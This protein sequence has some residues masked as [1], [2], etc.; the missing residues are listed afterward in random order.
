MRLSEP[1]CRARVAQARVGRL[2]TTG[3][4]G[5][6]HLVPVTFALAGDHLLTAV[7]RKPKSTTRLRRLRNISE[8]PLVSVLVD[9][10]ED[11]WTKLWWVRVDGTAVIATD[12]AA[13]RS[14]ADALAAKYAQ[15][16]GSAPG[17]PV[18]DIAIGSWT[19]WGY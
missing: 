12:D 13:L 17:G 14:A 10:Y 19:G 8:N 4:D 3:S 18:I 5:R 6:P 16:W 1:E 7:D 15:Y 11:D 2:A 9:H